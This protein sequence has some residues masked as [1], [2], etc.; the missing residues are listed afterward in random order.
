MTELCL[1][2]FGTLVNAKSENLHRYVRVIHGFSWDK[3][4][5]LACSAICHPDVIRKLD[6]KI[7]APPL[8]SGNEEFTISCSTELESMNDIWML[9]EFEK[10]YFMTIPTNVT[11]VLF[12]NQSN[13]LGAL[14]YLS[15]CI[16]FET[17]FIFLIFQNLN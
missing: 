11:H 16:Q 7:I 2:P 8:A 6:K 14:V 4:R 1:S 3:C 9:S 12:L 10:K 15:V 17:V 13:K 5:E